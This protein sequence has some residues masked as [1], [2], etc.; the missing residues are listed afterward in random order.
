MKFYFFLLIL[1]FVAYGQQQADKK[2]FLEIGYQYI[3]DIHG[4]AND[5]HSLRVAIL[6]FYTTISIPIYEPKAGK[7]EERSE[8]IVGYIYRWVP[9]FNIFGGLGI[10]SSQ[11]YEGFCDGYLGDYICVGL[12]NPDDKSLKFLLESGV[13]LIYKIFSVYLTLRNP[14]SIG[15]GT[16]IVF[17]FP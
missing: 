9:W 10:S 16:G 6:S 1:V 13:Q 2:P 8:F 7:Y 3:S 5:M 4:F 14:A 17:Y 15:V 11:V 12:G